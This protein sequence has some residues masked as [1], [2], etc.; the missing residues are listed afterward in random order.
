[1]LKKEPLGIDFQKVDHNEGLAPYFREQLRSELLEWCSSPSNYK[2]NGDPYNLYTD[3]LVIYTTIDSKLQKHA[4]D[5][6]KSHMSKLQKL[7]YNHW[8]GR[9]KAPYPSDMSRKDI[10]RLIYQGIKRSER[11]RKLKNQGKTDD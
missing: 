7:F 3:G 9:S 10:N 5:A 11:Y 1:M 2:S 4:E 8:K 6:V